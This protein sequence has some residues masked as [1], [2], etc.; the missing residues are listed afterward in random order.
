[1]TNLKDRQT[2]KNKQITKIQID[3]KNESKPS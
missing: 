1:M 2:F 3:L